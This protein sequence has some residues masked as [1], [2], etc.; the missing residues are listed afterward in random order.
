MRFHV[1]HGSVAAVLAALFLSPPVTAAEINDEQCAIMREAAR[2][3]LLLNKAVTVES[4]RILASSLHVLTIKTLIEISNKSMTKELD[5]LLQVHAGLE[6]V[7]GALSAASDAAVEP[8]RALV[9]LVT[10]VCP[11]KP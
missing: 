6:A 5:A 11:L 2:A 8:T 4:A 7:D 10:K 1:A 3:T 9:I